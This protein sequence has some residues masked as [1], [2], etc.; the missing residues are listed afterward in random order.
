[1][2]VAAS[3]SRRASAAVRG[4]DRE[5]VPPRR[6]RRMPSLAA[7]A[8]VARRCARS[9]SPRQLHSHSSSLR[10]AAVPNPHRARP[11]QSS[12]PWRPTQRPRSVMRLR[13]LPSAPCASARKRKADRASERTVPSGV[14]LACRNHEKPSHV[15]GAVAVTRPRLRVVGV[16][17]RAAFV[18][19][20]RDVGEARLRRDRHQTAATG[21]TTSSARCA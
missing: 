9:S 6:A 12:I 2:T 15:V 10:A 14:G 8:S 21:V 3:A 20:R 11:Q 17:E 4:L 7:M 16:F 19:H 5:R 18:G 13:T 1:M